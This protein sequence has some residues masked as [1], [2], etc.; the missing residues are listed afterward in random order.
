MC[1]LMGK[2]L[3]VF[4]NSCLLLRDFELTNAKIDSPSIALY[5]IGLQTGLP[6]LKNAKRLK[7]CIG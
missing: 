6:D 7:F 4:W 1:I 3:A 2:S 5:E